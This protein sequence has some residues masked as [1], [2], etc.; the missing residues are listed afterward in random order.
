MAGQGTLDQVRADLEQLA[1]LGAH[2]VVLDTYT[3]DRVAAQGARD[4]ALADRDLLA[5]LAAQKVAPDTDIG[6][7]DAIR[8]LERE[9]D[10]LATLAGR[11]FDLE[12][13]TLR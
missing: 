2:Y 7:A 5:A 3:E 12:R 13:Q 1:A 8:Y 9:W 11:V 4:Q 6:H 10:M